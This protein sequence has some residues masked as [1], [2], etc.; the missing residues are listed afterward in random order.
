[1]GAPVRSNKYCQQE[2]TEEDMIEHGCTYSACRHCGHN[3]NVARYRKQ[4][5]EKYG[6]SKDDDGLYRFHIPKRRRG[7]AQKL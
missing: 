6:L 1:M 7:N 5:I 4:I 2:Y 3:C